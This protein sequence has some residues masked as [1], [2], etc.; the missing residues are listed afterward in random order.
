MKLFKPANLLSIEM[1]SELM[2]Y[3]QAVPSLKSFG[4]QARKSLATRKSFPVLYL[5]I[6]KVQQFTKILLLLIPLFLLSCSNEPAQK[7]D[8]KVE[9]KIVKEPVLRHGDTP[10]YTSDYVCPLHCK[11]SGSD[12]PGVCPTCGFD[13]VR[14]KEHVSNGHNH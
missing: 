2:Y 3:F 5:K 14:L 8:G 10:A 7:Y 11:N 6:L 13:Y 9:K 4:R 12:K 1:K